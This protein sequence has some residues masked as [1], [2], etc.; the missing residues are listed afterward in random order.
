MRT[1]IALL[2]TST[3]DC[4]A[5]DSRSHSIGGGVAVSDPGSDLRTVKI[6]TLERVG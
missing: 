6:A 2:A 1:T 3:L 4:V 5:G